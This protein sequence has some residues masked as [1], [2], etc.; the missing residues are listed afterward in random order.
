MGKASV[1]V[2]GLGGAI[3]VLLSSAFV[4]FL[5]WFIGWSKLRRLWTR[6]KVAPREASDHPPLPQSCKQN[7]FCQTKS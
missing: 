1:W 7:Y 6:R 3:G 4:V 2:Q 5:G